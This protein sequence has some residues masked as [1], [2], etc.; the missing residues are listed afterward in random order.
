MS[1]NVS[2]FS[3][4]VLVGCI[5]FVV[6]VHKSPYF[7]NPLQFSLLFLALGTLLIYPSCYF[8]LRQ[9]PVMWLLSF[10]LGT[11]ERYHSLCGKLAGK[12]LND[13]KEGFSHYGDCS[14]CS[15]AS[16]GR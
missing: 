14:V 9:E 1:S 10:C 7:R 4:V 16:H 5:L 11:Q 13:Y 2:S 12:S 8:I 3:Q 6:V 15:W